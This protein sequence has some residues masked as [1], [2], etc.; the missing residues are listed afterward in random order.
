MSS[1]PRISLEARMHPQSSQ[2]LFACGSPRSPASSKKVLQRLPRQSSAWTWMETQQSH[3]P[4]VSSC[5][6]AK[7]L[8]YVK[9]LHKLCSALKRLL[10]LSKVSQLRACVS[11]WRSYHAIFNSSPIL[12][13][14]VSSLLGAGGLKSEENSGVAF[15]GESLEP[16]M[17]TLITM[18]DHDFNN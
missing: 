18:E 6:P 5:A 15:P 12:I 14:L 9:K 4:Q 3:L 16:Y 7:Q 1:R 2:K 13:S 17:G 11:C 8:D 10:C